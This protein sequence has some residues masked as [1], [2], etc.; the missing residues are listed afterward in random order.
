MSKKYWNGDT[1]KYRDAEYTYREWTTWDG[2]EAS[3][4]S[5][6]DKGLLFGLDEVRITARTEKEM[7]EKIDDYID[8]RLHKL[9]MQ[10]LSRRAASEFYET[11]FIK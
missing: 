3:G 10:D 9:E 6:E 1:P 5:C 8:N 2:R 11:K 7:F 4:F